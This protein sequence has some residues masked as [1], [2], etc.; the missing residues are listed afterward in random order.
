MQDE[1]RVGINSILIKNLRL[2]YERDVD[3]KSQFYLKV[4]GLYHD[5]KYRMIY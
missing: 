2:I 5:T 4:G 3:I 1:N